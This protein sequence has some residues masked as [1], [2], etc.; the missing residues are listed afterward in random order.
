MKQRLYTSGLVFLVIL[1]I[2]VFSG[3]K[4]SGGEQSY[5]ASVDMSSWPDDFPEFKGGKLFQIHNDEDTGLLAGA[6]FSNIKNPET[7]YKNYKTALS[8][9]GWILDEDMSSEHVWGGAYEKDPKSMHI[10]IQKDGSVAQL[11]YFDD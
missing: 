2:G 1:G 11:F 5:S 8:N 3:C 10:T 6:I 9:K 7:A 4:E